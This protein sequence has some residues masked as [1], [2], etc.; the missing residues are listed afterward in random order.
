MKDEVFYM[1]LQFN[2]KNFMSI[3]NEIVLS[4]NA[5]SDKKHSD[6]L[7]YSNNE[8]VLPSIAIYGANAAG[9]SNIFKALTAAILLV[10]NS[11]RMQVNM[12]MKAQILYFILL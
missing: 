10:R 12:E 2:V 5:T 3:K 8:K 6:S 11:N 1:L 9:K 7:L 4:L